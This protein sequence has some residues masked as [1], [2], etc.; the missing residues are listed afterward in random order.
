M[1]FG[2]L[3]FG[4]YVPRRRLQR[5][6]IHAANGWFAGGL[7]GLAKG[8]RAV[9]H[10]DEDTITLAVEAARNCLGERDRSAIDAVTLASTSH[11]FADRQNATVVKEAL[12]LADTVGSSDASGGLRAGTSALL[13]A[14]L[15]PG[16]T[17]L[18]TAAEKRQA[19]P[20]SENEMT[21]GDAAAAILVG[22]GDVVARLIG[23]HSVSTDFVDHF[24]ASDADTDYGWEGRWIRD[25]GYAKIGA[26]ALVA[27][28]TKFGISGDAVDHL[29]V[30]ITLRGVPELFA[31]KAGIPADALSDTLSAS[32][33]DSGAA[34]PLLLLAAALE[35]AEP[36]QTIVVLGYGQGVDVLAFE[37]TEALADVA[38]DR[39]AAT[40]AR[41]VA[42]DNYLR[43]LTFTGALRY[44]LGMRAEQD[45]KTALTALYRNRRTVLGLVGGR[46]S[47]T[48]TIQ[49]TPSDISVNQNERAIGTQEE[50]PLADVS[51]RILTFTADA[52]TF[53]PDPPSRYGMVEFEGGGRMMAEFADADADD[54]EVGREM[55]MM[56]RIKAI[57]QQRD[58]KR[59]FW[60]ATPV[61]PA[62]GKED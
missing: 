61:G 37:T 40:L 13:S 4:A 59:Y 54:I 22:E 19:A 47:K 23:H 16:R 1:S 6:A 27:A 20:A 8:E 34:H 25:E 18:C 44:E 41:R 12:N 50:Y 49:F 52:L 24:R 36:G 15:Q 30:P 7:K 17:T 45:Q 57:D 9:A 38:R 35:R 60:K 28:L 62:A 32:V 31:K 10:W 14:L 51:A 26:N 39:V 58:F 33:G 53:S 21:F 56:F 43:H 11:V 48:G 55:R 3:D 29:V 42:E 2:I 5:S 46:C